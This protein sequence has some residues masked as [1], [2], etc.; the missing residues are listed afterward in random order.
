MPATATVTLEKRI[1]QIK[2]NVQSIV[3]KILQE[4]APPL[5]INESLEEKVN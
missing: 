4:P 3:N 5:S 2:V 1:D